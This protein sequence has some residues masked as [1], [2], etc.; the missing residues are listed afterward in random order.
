MCGSRNF[1]QRGGGG[2]AHVIT[3]FFLFFFLLINEG[4]EDPN[5]DIN[6]PSWP[7]IECWLGSFVIFRGP[8]KETL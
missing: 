6:G 2:V 5:T 4:I 7:N 1:Y 8:G 3:F